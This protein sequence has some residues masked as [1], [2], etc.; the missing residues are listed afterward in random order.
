MCQLT[1]D[2]FKPSEASAKRNAIRNLLMEL[3][4]TSLLGATDG[5]TTLAP[6]QAAVSSISGES[7]DTNELLVIDEDDVC[8]SSGSKAIH[9]N[10]VATLKRQII[11]ESEYTGKRAGSSEVDPAIQTP[12]IV[13]LYSDDEANETCASEEDW[14][15]LDRKESRSCPSFSFSAHEHSPNPFSSVASVDILGVSSSSELVSNGDSVRYSSSA[16]G[17]HSSSI[18]SDDDFSKRKLSS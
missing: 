2:W 11:E 3:H 5:Q 17:L 6:E 1:R 14:Q 18:D 13:D 10:L 15:M 7:D 8:I 9:S 4:Q 12:L 16:G